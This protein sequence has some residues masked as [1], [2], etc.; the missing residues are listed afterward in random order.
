M[1]VLSADAV[2]VANVI[3]EE[4]GLK[5][6]SQGAMAPFSKLLAFVSFVTSATAT[7]F[8]PG[9]WTLAQQG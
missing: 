1:T 8:V 7:V 6:L 5:P 3:K 2:K 9:T 4:W